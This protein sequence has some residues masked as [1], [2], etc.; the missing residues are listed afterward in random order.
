MSQSVLTLHE[1]AKIVLAILLLFI[2]GFDSLLVRCLYNVQAKNGLKRW[3]SVWSG[4][5]PKSCSR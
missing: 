2:G 5:I 1:I 3:G 4:A